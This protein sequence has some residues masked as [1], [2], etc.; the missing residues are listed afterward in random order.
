MHRDL[1]QLSCN[2][3]L[4]V[5]SHRPANKRIHCELCKMILEMATGSFRMGVCQQAAEEHSP[6]L[7][8]WYINSIIRCSAGWGGGEGANRRTEADR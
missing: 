6:D 3:V 7:M 2:P 8:A 1:P 5:P 4:F